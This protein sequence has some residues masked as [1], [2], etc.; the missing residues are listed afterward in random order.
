MSYK[1]YKVIKSKV[2]ITL[3]TFE[4]NELSTLGSSLFDILY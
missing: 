1:V 2:K 3:Q 4:L